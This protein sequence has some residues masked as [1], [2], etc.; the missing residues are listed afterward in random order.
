MKRAHNWQIILALILVT[1]SVFFYVFHYI[2]F[3]DL[4][5]IF[6]YLIGDIA[7]LS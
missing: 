1:L 7:F 6:I 2:V 3:R 4:H 5:H